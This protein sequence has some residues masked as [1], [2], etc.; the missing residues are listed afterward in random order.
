MSTSF[1]AKSGFTVLVISYAI[2]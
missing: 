2:C 1:E